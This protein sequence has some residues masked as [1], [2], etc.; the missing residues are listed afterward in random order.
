[1][2]ARAR[3]TVGIACDES[4]FVGGS[5][6]GGIRVFAH[7]SLRVEPDEATA[8]VEEVR[9][10]TGAGADELKASRLNRPWARDVATWLVGPDGPLAGRAAV[11]VTDT[12]LF[13]LA[14]LA[15][16]CLLDDPPQ[17]WWA[18][19]RDA[20]CWDL[21][22]DL[23]RDP[24][25]DQSFLAG[26]RDLLWVT[27]KAR[28]RVV[29]DTW[30]AVAARTSPVLA[31]PAALRRVA[32]YLGSPPDTPLTEP[33]LPA[34]AW[35]LDH[36]SAGGD[37]DVV[38]DEQSVLTSARVEI[39]GEVLAE[40]HPGRR[41][42]GLVRVDSRVDDRVQLADLVAGV[43]RRTVEDRVQGRRRPTIDVD[44]LLADASVLPAA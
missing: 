20:G 40:R 2:T 27:R 13:G 39:L 25:P 30:P 28:L 4:G 31:T 5:L 17:G 26:A 8:L 43:V 42:A 44:H 23:H 41:L 38:H 19:D 35:A 6:F 24:T 1:M 18:A 36:W 29:P 21:A 34:L 32:G 12:R 3:P 9:R 10:R 37:P 11:H 22:L 16:V 14:R 33:L 15:Q 7:A